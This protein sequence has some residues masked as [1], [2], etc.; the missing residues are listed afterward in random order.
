MSE[1]LSPW[2]PRPSEVVLQMIENVPGTQLFLMQRQGP[3]SFV[4]CEDGAERNH[5]VLFGPRPTCSCR[6]GRDMELCIHHIFVMLRV[7]RLSPNN[8]IIW[9]L[10][11]IDRE[12]DEALWRA[13]S[14]QLVSS[15]RDSQS[16]ASAANSV[17][18]R[19][20]EQEDACSIC[21][22]GMHERGSRSAPELVW[23]QK[24]CGHNVHARCLNVWAKH[25]T[26]LKQELTCPMCRTPW[27]PFCWRPPAALQ[28]AHHKH[29]AHHGSHCKGCEQGPV[30][31]SLYTCMTCA[32]LQ[33]CS[34]CFEAGKHP[35]HS[36][37][38]CAHPGAPDQPAQRDLQAQLLT[39]LTCR[40]A[41][42]VQLLMQNHTSP[43]SSQLSRRAPGQ[44]TSSV[45]MEM[46]QP[47]CG[48]QPDRGLAALSIGFSGGSMISS[49]PLQ[50]SGSSRLN[51]SN[52][53]GSSEQIVA[54][55]G[56][57]KPASADR[58]QG[59]QK[60]RITGPQGNPKGNQKAKF[61]KGSKGKLNGA[62][63]APA[64]VKG[65]TG[66]S[67]AEPSSRAAV[68]QLSAFHLISLN[69]KS[70]AAVHRCSPLVCRA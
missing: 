22:E 50:R 19:P 3:M 59:K 10:S 53:A 48:T 9:Q 12:L 27:G 46:N 49:Q 29:A 38:C 31:G 64:D 18:C 23:C 8:P 4:L 7:L 43:S 54:K 6:K 62:F 39:G 60:A 17:K 5:K 42:S 44:H 30:V 56:V 69:V 33:L 65:K 52:Q 11:L 16:K 63:R 51:S 25:Q 36:F 34:G 26:T 35:Q 15:S 32:R 13:G 14:N 58:L 28:R 40:T 41:G 24:G 21:Y 45:L 57:P 68:Q 55:K 20:L 37:S 67:W 2:R 61:R 47:G 70:Q 66:P 1:R